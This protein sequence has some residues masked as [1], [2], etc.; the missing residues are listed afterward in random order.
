MFSSLV[1]SIKRSSFS[2]FIIEHFAWI[3]PLLRWHLS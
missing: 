2:C 3:E 1:N